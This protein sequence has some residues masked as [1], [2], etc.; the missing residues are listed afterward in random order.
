MTAQDPGTQ[1]PAGDGPAPDEVL[2]VE[3]IG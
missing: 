2:R 1:P 3:H